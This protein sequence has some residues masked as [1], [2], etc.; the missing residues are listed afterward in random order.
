LF[1]TPATPQLSLATG[2]PN[3]TFVATHVPALALTTTAAGQLIVG[4][5]VSFT[6]TLCVQVA[7]F[8]LVS[9]T[10]QVTVVTPFG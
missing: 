3:A 8:P 7:V 1:V 4:F 2:L 9:V 5:S 6:V 10:V